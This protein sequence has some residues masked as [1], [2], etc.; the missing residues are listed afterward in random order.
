VRGNK[1]ELSNDRPCKS[2]I[3]SYFWGVVPL[4]CDVVFLWLFAPRGGEKIGLLWGRISIQ[5]EFRN[6]S[7]A[8]NYST[9]M[10]R[11]DEYM[12]LISDPA[13]QAIMKMICAGLNPD[14]RDSVPRRLFMISTRKAIKLRSPLQASRPKRL[15]VSPHPPH[16]DILIS[17]LQLQAIMGMLVFWA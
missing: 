6:S 7:Q 5:V 11:E 15:S 1:H 13:P 3:G 10:I 12:K 8:K 14:R 16:T 2:R 17:D 4:L 9:P